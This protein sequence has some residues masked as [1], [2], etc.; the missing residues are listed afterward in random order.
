MNVTLM[1]NFAQFRSEGPCAYG[2]FA[3]LPGSPMVDRR[4][5]TVTTTTN[6]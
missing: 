6:S 3:L 4:N 1:R 2:V 5:G